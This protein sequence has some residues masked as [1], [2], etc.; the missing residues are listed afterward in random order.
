M[1]DSTD[2]M[3]VALVRVGLQYEFR[4]ENLPVALAHF[5]DER[6]LAVERAVVTMME[7]T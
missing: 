6:A 5:R 7:S 2:L 4:E 1:I 3:A